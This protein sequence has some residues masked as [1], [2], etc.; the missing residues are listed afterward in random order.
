M[1]FSF[2][3][4]FSKAF[5]CVSHDLILSKLKQKYGI[6][7]RLLKFILNYLKNR[8]QRVVIDGVCSE[9]GD[10]LSGVPQGSI[11]GPL[12][13]VLFIDD[14][15]SEVTTG[16]SIALYADDTK[17]WR[18]IQSISDT[19][20]LQRTIDNLA[21]WALR[22]KMVFHPAKCKVLRVNASSTHRPP[23][24]S[25]TLH[26][27]QLEV[28]NTH[29]DLGV[30][31][32]SDSTWGDQWSLK[33]TEITNRLCLT[34]LTCSFITNEKCRRSLYLTMIRSLLD[35]ASPIWAPQYC[36][37]LDSFERVQKSAKEYKNPLLSGSVMFPTTLATL[38]I[39]TCPN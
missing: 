22:N 6:N 32:S 27:H 17:I 14:I 23:H 31:I 37:H 18:H 10:V 16:T 26:G 9:L 8:K 13:F 7:G 34:R 12:L 1:M 11:L 39:T 24:T 5:D 29:R 3:F 35:H 15:V 21:D 30:L 2:Y 4:D 28:V 25:Y 38:S 36:T 19:V 33:L 20:S